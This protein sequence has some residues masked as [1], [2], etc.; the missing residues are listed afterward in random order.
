MPLFIQRQTPPL[1]TEIKAWP[2]EAGF[3]TSGRMN[4]GLIMADHQYKALKE[5]WK[6]LLYFFDTLPI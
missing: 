6:V 3:F 2:S 5:I 1:W 4:I